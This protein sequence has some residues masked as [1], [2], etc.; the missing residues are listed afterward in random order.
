MSL[1]LP[2]TSF[3]SPL[4]VAIVSHGNPRLHPLLLLVL[5]PTPSPSPNALGTLRGRSEGRRG[6]GDLH[7]RGLGSSDGGSRGR[8]PVAPRP[9]FHQSSHH[10]LSLSPLLWRLVAGNLRGNGSSRAIVVVPESWQWS[11]WGWWRYPALLAFSGPFE[12]LEGH[13]WGSRPFLRLNSGLQRLAC[14]ELLIFIQVLHH[15]LH[16]VGFLHVHDGDGLI[17]QRIVP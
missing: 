16:V 8:S 7:G 5:R 9:I 15:R 4:I 11:Q 12:V 14:D 17:F 13:R 6:R 10:D 1:L 3:A 2:P